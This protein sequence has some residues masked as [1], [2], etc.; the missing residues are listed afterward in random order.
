MIEN[1]IQTIHEMLVDWNKSHDARTKLQYAYGVTGAGLVLIA[2]LVS[3][4]NYNLGQS[5]LF[6]A[7]VLI[8]IFIANAILWA[9]L[10]SFVISKLSRR[11]K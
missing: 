2:G 11:K 7:G 1:M 9:L 8:V 10:E 3:L 4:V 6:V 5:I